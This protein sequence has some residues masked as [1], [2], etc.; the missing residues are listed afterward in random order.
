MPCAFIAV[1]ATFATFALFFVHLF[2]L[3]YD[4]VES[5]NLFNLVDNECVR[6]Q[7]EETSFLLTNCLAFLGAWYE[8]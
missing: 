8:L 1:F 7:L 6:R 4:K 2:F 5:D 3:E